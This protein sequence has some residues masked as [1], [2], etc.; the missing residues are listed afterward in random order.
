MPAGHGNSPAPHGNAHWHDVQVAPDGHSAG[1]SSSVLPSQSSSM[2]L[3]VSTCTGWPTHTKLPPWHLRTPLQIV[4]L[5]SHGPPSGTFSSIVPSQSSSKLLQT[6]GEP[7]VEPWQTIWPFWHTVVPTPQAL[8]QSAPPVSSSIVP[9][10]SSST[11]LQASVVGPTSPRHAPQC[12]C[13]RPGTPGCRGGRCRRRGCRRA[14]SSTAR[15]SRRRCRRSRCPGRR[16]SPGCRRRSRCSRPTAPI[17]AG[18]GALD[19]HAD[20]GAA[21]AGQVLVDRGRRS[22]RRGRCTARP[23]RRS[24]TR[25]RRPGRRSR[26][27]GC[28]RP[29]WSR[30]GPGC[31]CCRS[32]RC[33]GRRRPGGRCPCRCRA[34]RRRRR[35]PCRGSPRRSAGRSRRRGRCRSRT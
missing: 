35:C 12:R 33:P 2:Q 25:P 15:R 7:M 18:L 17:D 4:P 16:R 23:C 5:A 9:S 8:E 34:G 27:R 32:A 14:G 10:Q 1:G 22:R 20:V 26:R 13:R 31:R 28:C 6:S 30:P 29:R 3:Q 11:P 24:S 19:A 21:V